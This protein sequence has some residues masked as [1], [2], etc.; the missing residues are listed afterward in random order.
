MP[1]GFESRALGCLSPLSPW[2]LYS[3]P[4][5]CCP[6]G[7]PGP[8]L[9]YSCLG[10]SLVPYSVLFPVSQ[11]HVFSFCP[12]SIH[13]LCLPFL[14][15]LDSLSSGPLCLTALREC[16]SGQ[17]SG[18][19]LLAPLGFLGDNSSSPFTPS[20][21][22]LVLQVQSLFPPSA[23]TLVPKPAPPPQW[24]WAFILPPSST[25][26]PLASFPGLVGV[27]EVRL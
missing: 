2:F 13:T 18:L 11:P 17:E 20:A 25:S 14:A 26:F 6:P 21:E 12:H 15:L 10:P 22:A 24:I 16:V 9:L 19:D 3:S 4:S 5:F 1:I 8:S 23:A 27:L 7:L